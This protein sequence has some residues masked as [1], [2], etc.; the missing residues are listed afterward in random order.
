MKYFL[1]DDNDVWAMDEKGNKFVFSYKTKKL[2]PTDHLDLMWGGCS[3][4][5]SKKR[6]AEIAAV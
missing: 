5:Y 1:D 6:M 4:E 3:E 2:E